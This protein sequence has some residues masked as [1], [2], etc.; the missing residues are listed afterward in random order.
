MSESHWALKY[1]LVNLGNEFYVRTTGKSNYE[2]GLRTKVYKT[3]DD[4]TP[5]QAFSLHAIIIYKPVAAIL[6]ALKK[7]VHF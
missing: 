2:V 1:I 6:F 4:V 7:H 5:L 3:F